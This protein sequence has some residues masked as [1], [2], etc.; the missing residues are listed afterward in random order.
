[1]SDKKKV[2]QRDE[3]LTNEELRSKYDEIYAR[4][5]ENY[6]SKFEGGKNLS[7]ANEYV[8]A[9]GDWNGKSVVDVGCGTGELLRQVAARG[10]SEVI[11]IDYSSKAIDIAESRNTF[12]NARY[13]AGDIFTI[14]PTRCDVVISCGTIEHSN[15]P[16]Q[17]LEVLRSWCS[18]DGCI[19]VTCPHFI[20]VRGI[21]WTALSLLQNVPMSLTDLHSIHPWQMERWCDQVNLKVREFTTCDYERANGSRLLEDF[22]KRLRNALRDAGIDNTNVPDYIDHLSDLVLYMN[23]REDLVLD[24]ATAVY[25]MDKM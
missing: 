17:F 24:G 9:L 7:Q 14:D 16:A 6:F 19:I 11:G 5:E 2:H 22:D 8:L 1:M 15:E 3:T 10:A 21:V 20:N 12:K 23:Q 25:V 4:G 13:V 18:S